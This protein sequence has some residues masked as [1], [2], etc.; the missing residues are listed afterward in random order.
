MTNIVKPYVDQYLLHH[1]ELPADQKTILFIDC[2][3]VHIG[4]EF[5]AYVLEE[6][7]NIFLIFVPANCT[8]E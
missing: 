7:P 3:P 1:P 8:F 6:F 4:K 5:Q 2:Y